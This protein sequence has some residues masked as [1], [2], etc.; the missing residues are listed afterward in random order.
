ML[1][2]LSGRRGESWEDGERRAQRDFLFSVQFPGVLAPS[3]VGT[4][5]ERTVSCNQSTLGRQRRKSRGMRY[6]NQTAA[7]ARTRCSFRQRQHAQKDHPPRLLA[8]A[9]AAAQIQQLGGGFCKC[10]GEVRHE[11]VKSKADSSF[12]TSSIS[13]RSCAA[14]VQ[15]F[16]VNSHKGS[17]NLG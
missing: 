2:R 8:E 1:F 9:L 10:V 12:N 17:V 3:P 5:L 6:H 14:P 16:L 4:V 7:P 11:N 13:G 15:H